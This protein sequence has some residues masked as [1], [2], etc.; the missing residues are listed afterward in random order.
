MKKLA[1]LLL[2]VMLL[3]VTASA[4]ADY[5]TKSIYAVTDGFEPSS[6]FPLF[7]EPVELTV[8]WRLNPK[9]TATL[10]D[11]SEM[12][13]F[14]NL[15]KMA[16]CTFKF[17]H[18]TEDNVDEQ[19]NLM[20]A[21]GDYPDIIFYE[22]WYKVSG[23]PDTLI[24]D[25][26]IQSLNQYLD[27]GL[28]PNMTSIF[29]QY[30]EIK[31]AIDTDDGNWYCFPCVRYGMSMKG[32]WGYLLRQD[33]LDR[34][35]LEI[36]TTVDDVEKVL[37]AFRDNDANGNGDP[38]DEIPFSAQKLDR[39]MR[40]LWFWRLAADFT[41]ENGVVSHGQYNETYREA[42]TT[43][44]RWYEE[45]LI[46]P[47]F[48]TNDSTIML[49]KLQNDRV[50]FVYNEVGGQTQSI[51]RNWANEG[52]TDRVFV[53][54]PTP[55]AKEGQMPLN[56]AQDVIYEGQ[57]VAIGGTTKYGKEIAQLLD[58]AYSREGQ[59]MINFGVEG[60]SYT[61]V[62]GVPTLTD[63]VMNNPDGLSI[64]QAIAHFTVGSMTG[65]F[66]MDRDLRDQRMLFY[67]WQRKAIDAWNQADNTRLTGIYPTAE[68]S[69]RLSEITSELTTYMEECFVNFMTGKLPLDQFDAYMDRCKAMGVEEAI[70]IYQTAYDRAQ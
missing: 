58:Y 19:F 7:D 53:G 16:N 52:I 44:H 46:D 1:S 67:D 68:E 69:E 24:E 62:D 39:T 49:G 63:W 3:L 41:V 5:P 33:W 57:G 35:G 28:M 17:I 21:S 60:E 65:H 26:V 23:G 6:I 50:G 42:M 45:G 18:P 36:P 30:P 47:E 51:A 25:G 37:L 4:L 11:Y 70:Q 55:I 40:L 14:Q 22:K 38:S 10:L 64:D 9:A 2:A 13:Y 59:I 43:L 54:I 61:M 27:A 34:L 15:G 29:E 48:L 32:V 66:C 31:N 56:N 8:F 12:A 20:V